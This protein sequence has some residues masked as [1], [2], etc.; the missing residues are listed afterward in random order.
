MRMSSK[1]LELLLKSKSNKSESQSLS[2]NKRTYYDRLE[3]A[4]RDGFDF[5]DDKISINEKSMVLVFNRVCLLSHNDIL[6]IQ[7]K[8]M[9]RY[10]SLWKKRV[11]NLVDTVDLKEWEKN[12]VKKIKI[13]FLYITNNKQ[14]LDYD[15]TVGAVKFIIDGLTKSSAIF[16]DSLEFIPVILSRQQ[17]T[18]GDN[19]LIVVLTPIEE[20]EYEKYFSEEFKKLL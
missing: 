13:E 16:D 1:D 15:S 5:K 19:S 2:K 11:I 10:I 4:I 12:K 18:Q 20:E 17:K 3:D 7:F 14:Y 8:R 6:R 9:Y